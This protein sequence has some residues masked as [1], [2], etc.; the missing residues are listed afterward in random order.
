MTIPSDCELLDSNHFRIHSTVSRSV[1]SS[2]RHDTRRYRDGVNLAREGWDLVMPSLVESYLAYAATQQEEQSVPADQPTSIF[3]VTAFRLREYHDLIEFKKPETENANAVLLRHGYLGAS[4]K[5][6]TTAFSIELLELYHQLRRRQSN[7]SLQSM[8]KIICTTHNVTY[9]TSLRTKFSL[10]FDVYLKIIRCVQQ[11]VDEA[12]G[13]DKTWRAKNSCPACSY[14]RPN[15]PELELA[16]LHAMDGNNSLKRFSSR[17]DDDEGVFTSSYF[18]PPEEVDLY[19]DVVAQTSKKGVRTRA[20]K[21]IKSGRVELEDILVEDTFSCADGW[22]AASSITEDTV[23]VFD[24]TGVF[25]STCRHAIVEFIVEMRK[26]GELAKYGLATINAILKT[27]G[28]CQCVGYDIGCVHCKTVLKSPLKDSA[29][30]LKLQFVVDAFHGYSHERS[31]QLHFHPLYRSG[32]GIEDFATCERI[33]S[34]S[35]SAARLLRHATRYHWLQYIDLHFDQWDQDRYQDLTKFIYDNYRQALK[36]IHV[37]VPRIEA[38]QATFGFSDEDFVNWHAEEKEYI[39]LVTGLEA[40][41]DKNALAYVE[42][43]QALDAAHYD[44]AAGSVQFITVDASSGRMTAT[45]RQAAARAAATRTRLRKKL[46]LA[47]D[48]VDEL[49]RVLDIAPRWTPEHAKYQEVLEFLK[50]SEF[51]AIVE[52]LEGLVVQRLF[53]LGK[54]NLADT[55]VKLRNQIAKGI[56]RRSLTLQ[57]ALK[58]Y[59]EYA[60]L[61]TPPRPTVAYSDIVSYTLLGEFSL[62][63]QSRYDP[64]SKPWAQSTNREMAMKYWKVRRAREE[65]ERL[66]VETARMEAWI[67]DEDKK[68]Q[69]TADLLISTNPT[70]A[71]QVRLRRDRRRQVNQV[72]RSYLDAI[73]T[74]WGYSGTIPEGFEPS[75]K[76]QL[77]DNNDDDELRDKSTRL[78]D[79]LGL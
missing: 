74:I 28:T 25:L 58:K 55:A 57:A 66:N 65:I 9:T 40:A 42:A 3:N 48:A 2:G 68:W 45:E 51:L 62:L 78:G 41:F 50:N 46:N 43:L 35:N 77:V 69:E 16:H 8:V 75:S 23:K 79:F 14:K 71:Y 47:L 56:S 49:E 1:V 17:A 76:A 18:I 19:K 36:I 60:P 64:V 33:F 72:H 38:F 4:P 10:T 21:F 63:K 59:N 73:Y 30:N 27:Y 70:L 22:T 20:K 24:Q 32:C 53:E 15:E 34:S 39:N 7:F 52:K 44:A 5:Q 11:Q 37:N 29:Q 54:A 31:C 61:Q 26:S 6:P 13:R 12:M 67:R